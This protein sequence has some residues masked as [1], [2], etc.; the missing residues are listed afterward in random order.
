[1]TA[2][3][4]WD[5]PQQNHRRCFTIWMAGGGVK[6]GFEHG[7]TD[8]YGWN[9]QTGGVHIRDRN[10]TILHLLG[11]DHETLTYPFQG[12]DQRLTG[13]EQARVVNEILT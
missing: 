13:V 9:I 8:D 7:T 10:A 6:P 2:A 4:H 1:M 3:A 5:R 11:F 12:L